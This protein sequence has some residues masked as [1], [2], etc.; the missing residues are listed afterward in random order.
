MLAIIAIFA[1]VL[2]RYILNMIFV[3]IGNYLTK[4]F[5][6]QRDKVQNSSMLICLYVK[7]ILLYEGNL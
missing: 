5:T 3:E 7:K 4:Y 2:C 6:Q 1:Q